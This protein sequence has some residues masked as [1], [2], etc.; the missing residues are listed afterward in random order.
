MWNVFGM[1]KED[2][3]E[4]NNWLHA[5]TPQNTKICVAVKLSYLFKSFN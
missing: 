5:Y 3:S 4:N 2:L 1:E